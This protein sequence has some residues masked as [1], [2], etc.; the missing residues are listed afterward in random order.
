MHK[1]SKAL[2][3]FDIFAITN[4]LQ[5][6]LVGARVKKIYQKKDTFYFILTKEGNYTLV[7]GANKI[8]LTNYKEKFPL[9][10]GNF[11]MLL[12]KSLAGARLESITQHGLDRIVELKF[13]RPKNSEIRY[14]IAE[15]FADGNLILLNEKFGIIAPLRRQEWKARTIREKLPYIY[16]PETADLRELNFE[17]F[18]K[19]F[20][21]INS[22]LVRTLASN[23]GMGGIYA[24]EV[25]SRAN[26]QKDKKNS[27]LSRTELEKI[28]SEA[29][30][31]FKEAMEKPHPVQIIQNSEAIAVS[32]I[33]LRQ[34]QETEIKSFN[35][36]GEACDE[37]FVKEEIEQVSAKEEKLKEKYERIIGRQRKNL[38]EIGKNLNIWKEE[39]DK[40]SALRDFKAA[41]QLYD[42]IKKMRKKI[43]GVQKAIQKTTEKFSSVKSEEKLPVKKEVKERKWFDKFRNFETSDG[44]LVVC[45]KDATTNELLIKKN[46]E[47]ND[48]VFH[49]DIQGAP[50][51]VIKTGVRQ[52]S[53]SS[54]SEVAQISASYSKAWQRNLGAIDVYWVKPEQ[55]SKTAP[56]GEY[57][58]HGAF[59]VHGKKN[60]FYKVP[61]EIAVGIGKNFN[62]IAGAVNP[63]KN[64]TVAYA[65]IIPGDEKSKELAEKIKGS[66]L[67]KVSKEDAEAI[68]SISLEE[69]QRCIPA[70]K[71][72]L[73]E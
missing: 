37:F 24:E 71:G 54:L 63:V 57:V 29:K 55:L 28:Y 5:D 51:C 21:E 73:K 6:K 69:I 59:A 9:E 11:C 4:E 3:S 33:K 65:V 40:L 8:Y 19:I 7:I 14:I 46:T 48:I 43:P 23:F 1:H 2:T 38:A 30:N 32:P 47:K 53:D 50:F 20:S 15:L 12:R 67:R 72:R 62:V 66:W 56:A 10:P 34:F 44:F 68:K 22:D 27:G 45:G 64:R 61:L 52:V 31:L 60:Y 26:V 17:E 18:S 36:F 41:A 16:P 42:K 13:I 25:C 70:G 58:A 49:A 35:S 39:A